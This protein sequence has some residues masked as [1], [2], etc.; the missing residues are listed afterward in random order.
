MRKISR[1]QQ[2]LSQALLVL[3]GLFVLLPVWSLL[4]L[5]LDGDL[6]SFP[7][8]LSLLPGRFSLEVFIKVWHS[9]AQVLSFAQLLANSLIV[10]GGAA[11]G[12][13]ALG[14][15]MAY[16]FARFRF[17]GRKNGLFVLLVG[18]LLPPVALMTPLYVMFSAL[19]LRTS[20]IGLMLVYT[21]VSLPFC[22]WNLRAAFQAVPRELEEAAFLD[23]ASEWIA[24]RCVTLPLALPSMA[25]AVLAAFLAGYTEF[26][27]GWLFVE[28]A[29]NV[30]L[31]MALW[32]LRSLGTA[33][34]SEVSALALLMSLPV[35]ILFLGLQRTLM[36]RFLLGGAPD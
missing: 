12:A 25:V 34:W 5:A 35:V 31:A 32:G 13:A 4:R 22:I 18:A 30:T 24:F 6:K 3:T 8:E 29:S 23:G 26:A 15:G 2:I 33:P 27:I 9:P 19:G 16:A 17:P 10:A 28:R 1:G 11:I 7:T 14:A 36:D 21:A 20:L